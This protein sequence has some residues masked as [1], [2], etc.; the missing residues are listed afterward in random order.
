MRQAG[1]AREIRRKNRS[2][3]E[4]LLWFSY[5][6]RG[7]GALFSTEFVLNHF[8]LNPNVNSIVWLLRTGIR[9]QSSLAAYLSFYY[10]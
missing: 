5:K 4:Q 1:I 10:C 7:A 2:L 3:V 8:L 6:T 9:E